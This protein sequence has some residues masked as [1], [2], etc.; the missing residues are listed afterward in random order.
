[1]V[2]LDVP[3]GLLDQHDAWHLRHRELAGAEFL[4]FHCGFLGR[5]RDWHADQ[6]GYLGQRVMVRPW[7]A[8]PAELKTADAA[9]AVEKRFPDRDIGGWRPSW[10]DLERKI[11][12][13]PDAYATDAALGNAIEA[14]HGWV[15]YA[16]AAVYDDASMHDAALAPKST[17][18]QQFHGLIQT[19]WTRWRQANEPAG[20]ATRRGQIDILREEICGL[21]QQIDTL[22]PG[23]DRPAVNRLRAQIRK[24]NSRVIRIRVAMDKLGCLS[25]ACAPLDGAQ[26]VVVDKTV[27]I[28]EGEFDVDTGVSVQPGDRLLLEATGEIWPGVWRTGNTWPFGWRTVEHDPR[29]PLREGPDAHPYS[30]IGRLGS[31][32]YF[33]VGPLWGPAVPPLA[34]AQRLFLRVNHDAPGSGGGAFVCR[35]VLWR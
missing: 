14:F 21:R 4:R 5:L 13:E 27:S 26:P 6:P 31:P 33:W 34:T 25:G 12:D 10:D 20:C 22:S 11:A 17:Y 7:P 30:L 35:I 29:F 15:H 19:W 28:G 18:F 32:P 1:M 8:I 3:Q 2:T 24:L 9:A 16:V 23:L